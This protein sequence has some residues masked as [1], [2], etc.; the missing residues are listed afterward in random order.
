MEAIPQRVREDIR[1]D[2][3]FPA[4]SAGTA[5]ASLGAGN[6]SIHRVGKAVRQDAVAA[7]C[8][9]SAGC[10]VTQDGTLHAGNPRFSELRDSA[11]RFVEGCVS[12]DEREDL[13]LHF[14]ELLQANAGGL[15]DAGVGKGHDKDLCGRLKMVAS[16]GRSV[17]CTLGQKYAM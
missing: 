16:C 15:L 13:A 12:G 5:T 7:T 10:V 2:D 8:Q 4:I 1:A 6:E 9:V 14:E 11:Q 3:A 17:T